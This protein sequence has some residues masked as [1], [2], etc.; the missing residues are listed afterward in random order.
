VEVSWVW[1]RNGKVEW[2]K[3]LPTPADDP[4][5]T[6]V[7]V[8]EQVAIAYSVD[9]EPVVRVVDKHGGS[10]AIW[11]GKSDVVPGLA[12]SGTALLVAA[13]RDGAI[14]TTVVRP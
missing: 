7:G 2:T 4:H 1:I 6:A 14:A 11:Q 13:H 8:G 12:W 3:P 5:V 9:P 10:R